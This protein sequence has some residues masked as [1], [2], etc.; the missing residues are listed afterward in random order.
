MNKILITGSSGYIG[1]HLAALLAVY[2]DDYHLTGVDKMWRK[3]LCHE[4]IGQN[5]LE[6]SEITGKYD[7]VI[8][9]A[10]LVNV[11][12][13]MQAPMD[14]YRNNVIGTLNMLERVDYN[15]FIFASTG[16]ATDP[17]SPYGM[18]KFVSEQLV[19]Q[20]CKLNNKK[21]TIFRFY[22]VIG[23]AGYEPTN[24]DGLMYNLMKAKE[25]GLFHLYGIDYDM[26]PD[27]SAIRDYLHVTEVCQ[28]IKFAVDTPTSNSLIENLGHGK[29]HSVLEMVNAFK[30]ANNCD[31]GVKIMQR[32]EGDVA[33]TVLDDVSTYMPLANITIEEMLK[34]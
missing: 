24:V 17:A 33:K 13:S 31:F 18:S 8:H 9:L 11:G 21:C 26:L 7:T 3:Q 25:T 23:S 27:G 22:N 4:F 5:I 15:H 32:R 2:E 10:G 1:R 20:Y 16:A 12:M 19:R 29:G 14:Y 28:A 6:N 34:I 30:K